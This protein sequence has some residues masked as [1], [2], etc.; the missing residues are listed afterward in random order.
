VDLRENGFVKVEDVA[1]SF[2]ISKSGVHFGVE[3]EIRF[4]DRRSEIV[5]GFKASKASG[6]LGAKSTSNFIH[7]VSCTASSF[8]IDSA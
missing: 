3:S 8:G 7:Q 4:A 5:E 6:P 1:V 2:V